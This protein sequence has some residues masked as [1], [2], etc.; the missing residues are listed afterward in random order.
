MGDKGSCAIDKIRVIG[1]NDATYSFIASAFVEK[2]L[3][4][5]F[6]MVRKYTDKD[7][8]D[9]AGT[10]GNLSLVE[11]EFS[12]LRRHHSNLGRD[13]SNKSGNIRGDD[14]KKLG[15]GRERRKSRSSL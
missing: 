15:V 12:W 2:D 9:E 3:L 1:S 4:V 8:P 14:Y 7:V 5:L 13:G 6:T 10:G 11:N